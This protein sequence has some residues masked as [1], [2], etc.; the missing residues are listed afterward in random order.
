MRAEFPILR[1]TV[2]ATRSSTSTTPPATQ[3][4]RA[5]IDAERAVYEQDN[6]NIH[7]GVHRLSMLATEAYERRARQGAALPERAATAG[8]SSSPAGP[9]RRINLVAQSFGPA[10]REGRRRDARLRDRAPLEHRPLADA[11]RGK[12]ATLRVVPIDDAGAIDSRSSAAARRPHEPR[13]RRPR[14]ERARHHQPRAADDGARPRRRG[15][16]CSSTAPRACPTWRS[17]CA[18]WA[19]TSTRSRPQGL[20]PHR[21]RRPLRQG[22][23]PRGMPPWQGGGDMIP[24]SPSRRRPTTSCPTSS[25]RARRTSPARSAS[26]RP[27]TT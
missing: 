20:R 13:R 5:V 16:W 2:T 15:R 21:D 18:S 9:R 19:A 17:T 24:P 26:A 10:E 6:A 3:K 27:S 1:E 12:G 23:A 14:L 7:R 4:P 25:R 11:V 22:R 8:R